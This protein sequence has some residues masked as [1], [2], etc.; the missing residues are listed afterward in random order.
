MSKHRLQPGIKYDIPANSYMVFK[1]KGAYT[2]YVMLIAGSNGIIE[3]AVKNGAAHRL[4]YHLISEMKP[5]AGNMMYVSFKDLAEYYGVSTKAVY[6]LFKQFIDAHI[7][8]KIK[9]GQY[10]INPD[11]AWSGRTADRLKAVEEWN[12]G[13]NYYKEDEI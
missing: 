9:K 8:R 12:K 5:M 1:E 10:A 6:K 4:L 2:Q 13:K 3:N 7:I 11:I